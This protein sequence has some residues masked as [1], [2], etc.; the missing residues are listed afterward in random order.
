MKKPTK[1][2]AKTG[3]DV[4][5]RLWDRLPMNSD[6]AGYVLKM[7]FSPADEARMDTL[8]DR[9]REGLITPEELAEL[10]WYVE[11]GLVVS[12]LQS[13]ARQ[14]LKKTGTDSKRG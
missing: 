1:A 4:F 12:V 8:A 9:N 2:P 5:L 6:V 14:H 7:K 13:R 11:T 3:H 10:D